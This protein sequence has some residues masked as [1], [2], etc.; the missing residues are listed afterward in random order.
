MPDKGGNVTRAFFTLPPRLDP[1]IAPDASPRLAVPLVRRQ[2]LWWFVAH[3]LP[4][5][6][7]CIA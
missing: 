3:R 1:R 4:L 2:W 5:R 7:A 6:M